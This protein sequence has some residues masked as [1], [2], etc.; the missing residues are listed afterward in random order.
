MEW[1]VQHPKVQQVQAW[2][3]PMEVRLLE[4]TVVKPQVRTKWVLF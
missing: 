2:K 3:A 4:F 1:V